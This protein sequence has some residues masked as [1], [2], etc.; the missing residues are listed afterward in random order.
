MSDRK[1]AILDS[2]DSSQQKL[3]GLFSRLQPADWERP[4]QDEDQMWTVRQILAH[5]VNSQ[6]GM[7]GTITQISAGQEGVP[8]DFDVH[9]WNKRMVEKSADKTPQ[10]LLKE[11]EAG[12]VTLKQTVATLDDAALDKRGRH[13]SLEIMS[14]EQI[15]RLVGTHASDHAQTIADKL[16]MK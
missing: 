11:L 10:D 4:I 2:L 9:R 3:N 7:T 16:G 5:M 8:A 6:R 15:A 12:H 1:T 14:V 13:G